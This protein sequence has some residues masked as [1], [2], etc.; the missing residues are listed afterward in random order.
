MDA[1]V[2]EGF[3]LLKGDQPGGETVRNADYL[4]QFA[5]D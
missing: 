5:L 1:L 4:A 3:L 2:L